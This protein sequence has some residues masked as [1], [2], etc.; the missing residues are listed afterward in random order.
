[1]IKEYILKHKNI[2]VLTFFMDDRTFEF[3]DLGDIISEERLPYGVIGKE[4]RGKN[5]ALLNSWIQGR[6]LP[7]SR[8]DKLSVKEQFKVDELKTLTIQ[9]RALN[10]T[11]H[12]WLHEAD[13]NILWEKVNH[14]DNEF[15]EVKPGK[16]VIP[17]ID[18]SVRRDSPN[19][20]VRYI[21]MVMHRAD[22]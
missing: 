12:Y 14:F 13:N 20:C 4:S 3:E 22:I 18:E 19:L 8:K 21:G 7:E 16:D 10:L 9:A 17:G 5:A 2:P 6:G 1:M 15:D 11:D